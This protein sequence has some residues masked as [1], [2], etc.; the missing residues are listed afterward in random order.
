MNVLQNILQIVIALGIFNV[1]FLRFNKASEWRGGEA[2]SMKEEFDSY[3][4]PDWSVFVVGAFK[5]GF[6][7]LLLVGLFVPVVTEPA[8]VGLGLLMLVAVLMHV[9]VKDPPKRS[10]PALTLLIFCTLVAVL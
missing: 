5:V 3:G 7:V 10:L 6:A 2:G 1:W 4:L 9:K 8:A